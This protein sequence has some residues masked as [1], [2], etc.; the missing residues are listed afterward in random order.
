MNKSI[1]I[2]TI[3]GLK[4]FGTTTI[5]RIYENDFMFLKD[6]EISNLSENEINKLMNYR[7]NKSVEITKEDIIESYKQSLLI[8]EN[9]K[10]FGIQCL[11]ILDKKFPKYLFRI[12]NPV[13]IFYY[14]G[15]INL[16]L[17]NKRRIAIVG[18]RNP[19]IKG[20]KIAFSLAKIITKNEGIVV[21]GLASGIDTQAHL[22][23][24]EHD[25]STIAVL[26]SGLDVIYPK[27][28]TKIFNK[29]LEKDGCLLSEYPPKSKINKSNF[30]NR[31][32]IQ[33]AI[34]SLIIAIEA[35]MDS[36]TM[37][38]I[39]YGIQQNKNIIIYKIQDNPS[40]FYL[41]DK[42]KNGFSYYEDDIF[43]VR[44]IESSLNQFLLKIFKLLEL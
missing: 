19:S 12:N 15:N 16:L 18:T 9:C 42:H 24:L 23:T 26:G 6:L 32:R 21:S 34:S 30:V 35:S 29:I 39:N 11:S 14:K 10:K 5:K 33:S 4:G 36:G 25:K 27:E 31:N 37:H 13:V 20:E 2:N 3:L 7:I 17:E 40:G 43:N 1:I 44:K 41:Y 28:N 22:G 38:T 8:E